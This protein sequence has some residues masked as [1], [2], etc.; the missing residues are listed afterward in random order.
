MR[1]LITAVAGGRPVDLA[2]EAEDDARVADLAT[3]IGRALG[4][5]LVPAPA[6]GPPTLRV[7]GSTPVDA[8]APPLYLGAR[9]LDPAEPLA[10]SAVR[11]G[12]VLG[13]GERLPA[14]LV[15]PGGLVEVRI[16]SGPGAGGVTRLDAGEYAVG[17]TPDCDIRVAGEGLPGVVLRLRVRTDGVVAV[18]PVPEVVGRTREVPRR[19]RPLPGPIVLGTREM[20]RPRKP[21]PGVPL[22]DGTVTTDPADDVPLVHLDRAPLDAAAAWEPGQVLGAGPALLELHPVTPPD[23][24]LSPNPAGENLDFNRPPRILPPVRTTAFTLPGEP[25]R[26]EKLPLPLALMLLPVLTGLAMWWFTRSPLSLIICAL[27]PLMALSQFTSGRRQAKQR[28]AAELDT[29]LARTA[30]IQQDAFDALVEERAA[31]RRDHVDA[32]ETLLTAVGPRMRLWERRQADPDFLLARVGTADQS[33]E[34]SMRDPAREEHEGDLVW[35]APDVPVV[36]PLAEAGVTGVAGPEPA[37]LGLARFMLGQL[38]V[39]H[40]PADLDMVLLTD[41]AASPA[42]SWV[43]W[44]PHMRA[45]LGDSEL[46]HVG[47]DD[48]SVSLRIAELLRMLD[49]RTAAASDRSSLSAGRGAT[50]AQPVLVVLDGARRLRLLPGVPQLLQEGPAVRMYFLCLDADERLLPEECQVVVDVAPDV[51]TVRRTG[52]PTVEGVRPDLVSTAWAELVARSLAPVRDVS[53]VADGGTLPSSSRLLDVIRLDPPSEAAVLD[54]WRSVGRTTKAVIGEGGDGAF[55]IDIRHDGPH[56]LV[57]GTTGSGKSELLQTI[58]A[59]LAAGNRPDEMN[60]VL[61]DYK[62]GA[63]FKDC[64]HL[65]HT[66]GMV[67]DLDGHLTT[68]ALES[69]GAELRRR[70]HQL[71]GAG[72]KDIED[73]LAAK[74]PDDDPMPR[75]LIVIDEFAALVTELPDFVTGLVDIARRGRSLGVHLILATQRPAGVVSAEIKS[76]TNLRIALRVTDAG[77]STD[78][79]EAPDAA[80][81]AKSTPGRGYARLGHSN[82]VPFQSSRVGGRPRGADAGA[83]VRLRPV[84]FTTLGTPERE[85][86]GAEQDVSVPTDLAALVKAAQDASAASG[87]VAPPPPWLPALDSVVTLEQ[88]LE[89]FPA[90]VPDRERLRIPFGLTDVPAEQ[91]RGVA[92]LDLEQGGNLGIIS[93]PR[94]GRSTALRAIA[95]AIA[96]DVS[97]EDVHVYGVDC[98]NNALLPLVA[99]PHVGAVVT[100]NETDRMDRLVTRLRQLVSDRQQ[101]LAMAGFADVAEQRASVPAEQRMPYVVVLFDRWE[102]FQQAY[103]DLDGGRLVQ[104]WHQLLQ[105]GAGVGLRIVV[106]GDRT[107]TVGRMST[108]VEDKLMLRMVDPTD[109]GAIGMSSR[110]APPTLADGR[111]F[112]AEGLRE[113]QVALLDEDP[114]GTA[115]VA[116]LQRLGRD[117]AARAAG[118]DRE[119][120]PFRL[121]VLPARITMSEALGL[122]EP[123]AGTTIPVAVGG[124][125]LALRGL[126]AVDNGPGLLVTGGRRTG[127]STTLRTMA[128][129]AL[130]AGWKVVVIT[131]R[132]SPLRDL[133]GTPGVHGPFDAGSDQT[134]VTDLLAQLRASGTPSLTVVDDVE[135][136]GNDDWLADLVAEHLDRLRDSGSLL[137]GAG[138][139][140]DISSQYRGPAAT[141]KKSGSGVMLAPQSSTDAD[142]FGVR[143]ARSAY[144]QPMPPGGGYLVRGGSVE[145]VQVIWPEG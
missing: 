107:L 111:G 137:V 106:T 55:T 127:R 5:A 56:G 87:I 112:R 91:R 98:G 67:T 10:S 28:Y 30:R 63:A 125:T 136:V 47:V 16:T 89:Q 119:R 48:E 126:D 117:A 68:R 25:T 115:Q 22:P 9:L 139:P 132:V 66:V 29:Y 120:L 45:D 4:D 14:G 27:S 82:L 72:A 19:S 35:T 42:W 69:L 113:T 58:I 145:R 79:I 70:E 100:R 44:L 144:G 109:F 75:L 123:P 140:A 90:A 122:G 18:E 64:N 11:H 138:T 54:R 17:T 88:V 78:V 131:P 2:V 24:S 26:P 83:D 143:L 34:V 95:G 39:L 32:S 128:A 84:T 71:A 76:N 74:G 134:E 43:R 59:S 6:G 15:E 142:N 86:V 51:A 31:R 114:S 38:A 77:D 13:V 21:K 37:R 1:L 50:P 102:G 3:V 53:A 99:L 110:Q 141:L 52:H 85:Q 129:F 46:A 33:S 80:H 108:L 116:A 36:V 130:A 49:E 103:D 104:A 118:A 61:V 81:I 92:L 97:P 121:D 65:P 12:S 41:T 57:A 60:F 105:E 20:V 96:R 62:G 101:R 124:D 133:A 94:A 93:A 7:V 40:S 8:P 23:A 135:L 73:Y